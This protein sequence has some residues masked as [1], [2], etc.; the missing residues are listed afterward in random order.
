[1]LDDDLR[2]LFQ[3]Y[4]PLCG[5]VKCTFD[6]VSKGNTYTINLATDVKFAVEGA[7]SSASFV[8][9]ILDEPKA[10]ISLIVLICVCAAFTTSGQSWLKLARGLYALL[11]HAP[12]RP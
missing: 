8:G 2:I 10:L 12:F 11:N 4:N 1:M 7:S 3:T 9:R 6:D 5:T